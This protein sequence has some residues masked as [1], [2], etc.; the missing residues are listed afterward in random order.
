ML[1]AD[2]VEAVGVERIR[3]NDLNRVIVLAHDQQAMGTRVADGHSN[4]E[5]WIDRVDVQ[6]RHEAQAALRGERLTE[7]LKQPQYTPLPVEE[8][9]V[10][11]FA[12]VKGYLDK[13]PINQVAQWEASFL[14]FMHTQKS[15]VYKALSDKQELTEEI[16]KQL[17]EAIKAFQSTRG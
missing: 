5:L 16:E 6:L 13:V 7:L 9:V 10:C 11:I 8:Q 2:V 4:R 12:G 14:E 15:D 1:G 3:A 17:I